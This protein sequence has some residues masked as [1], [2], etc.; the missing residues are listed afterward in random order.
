M[1]ELQ[2][3]RSTDEWLKVEWAKEYAE[4]VRKAGYTSYTHEVSRNKTL[5]I[6]TSTDH[7][8]VEEAHLRFLGYRTWHHVS[9]SVKG[10][11]YARLKDQQQIGRQREGGERSPAPLPDWYDLTHMAY[12]HGKELGFD[13]SQAVWQYLPPPGEDKL[14]IAEALHLRQVR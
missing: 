11:L 12:I 5:F 3:L 7:Y 10:A 6:T 9:V 1:G 13:T 4:Y 2:L 8:T 14:N